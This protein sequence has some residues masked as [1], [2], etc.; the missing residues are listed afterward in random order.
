MAHRQRFLGAVLAVALLVACSDDGDDA[1]RSTATVEETTTITAAEP[2]GAF[3]AQPDSVPWPTEEWAT[4]EWP[5]GVDQAAVD[6]ATDTAFAAGAAERVRAVVVV[7]GGSIVY[8]RYSP[9][10]ADGPDEVMPSFSIAKSITSAM[11]GIL[12]RDGRLDIDEPAPVPAWHEEPDDPRA[13]ITVEHMLHMSTGMEWEEDFSVEGTTM[14]EMLASD[15]MAAYTAALTPSSVPGETFDYNTGTTILLA[16]ILGDEI[17]GNAADTR[18]FLE[19]ELFDKIGMDPVRTS[20]DAAGTWLGGFSADSTARDFAKFG[21]LYLR[22][23]QWD[24]EQILP[25]EWVE[26][27]RT[28]SPANPEYGAQWWLDLERPGVT[29]AIG[30]NGQVITVDPA[31]DLVIVQLSTVSGPLVLNHTE[32]IL[33]TFDD[34]TGAGRPERR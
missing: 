20:F 11:I 12:V 10:P 32:A 16:R 22:G 9:N 1:A 29:Y 19:E 15:D 24:G 6:A 5:A 7:H 27:T 33:D 31:H 34:Q 14:A 21:L 23:G 2:S 8:E 4:A 17:G 28:P 18:A 3:P 30:L 13:A 26:F 25:E